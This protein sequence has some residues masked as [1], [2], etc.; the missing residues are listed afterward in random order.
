MR[1][2]DLAYNDLLQIL[3][4][5]QTALFLVIM[6][7]AFTLLFGFL[8][9]GFSAET[10]EDP[11][12]P[13]GYLDRDGGEMADH[14]VRFLGAS[15]VLRTV[16]LAQG[17]DLD[18]MVA[19]G[20]LAAAVILPAGFSAAMRSEQPLPATVIVEK[21]TSAGMTALGE[22]QAGLH[23]LRSAVRAAQHAVQA[24]ENA[25]AFPDDIAAQ[26]YFDEA[27]NQAFS[28][29]E[30]PPLAVETRMARVSARP[31]QDFVNA[32]AHSSPGMMAQFAI[33]GLI[34]AAGVIVQERKQ[35]ALSR[36]L[37]TSIGRGEIILGHFLAMAAMVFTQFAL[38]IVF[39]QLF[40]RL[41]YFS[42]PWATLIITVAAVLFAASLGLLLGTLAKTEDQV[43][44][45]TLI[46]MFVLS[47]LGGA[48]V[49][50]E[51]TSQT[52]Q[53]IGH[54][55]PVAWIM[56]GYKNILLR[57]AGFTESL[58]PAGVLLG[59]TAL[60]V[61]LSVWRFRFE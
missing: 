56:D 27:F 30:D 51:F 32:F 17:D 28:A 39:G 49:P 47:G 21:E 26:G 24:Y 7:I 61:V 16:N 42:Q 9:G 40:L 55:S 11:R 1:A 5:K 58:L 15:A 44:I 13:V 8:F 25:L 20:Q 45:F 46:P 48:W 2:I 22:I 41:D 31:D 53:T 29:W 59:F 18:E 60:F 43:V 19:Q 52:V 54:F 4:D 36:L 50:L 34:G 12:L 10:D 6:P 38:L 14:L 37:T 33:A 23:R 3:R 57:G 35:G